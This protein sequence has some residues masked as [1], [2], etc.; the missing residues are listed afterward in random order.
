MRKEDIKR[1]MPVALF[2]VITSLLIFEVGGTLNLWVVRETVFPLSYS[3]PFVFGFLPVVAIWVFKFTYERFGLY[4]ITN[5]VLDLD[6]NFLVMPLVV[7]R[8]ILELIN[9]TYLKGFFVVTL[10]AFLIYGYQLWQE[11]ALV[12]A[13]KK[14]FSTKLEPAATKPIFEDEDDEDNR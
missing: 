8:G 6:F 12:P 5:L 9:F 14:L 4:V 13:V 10:H 1:Y 7:S 11:D 3:L 2:T